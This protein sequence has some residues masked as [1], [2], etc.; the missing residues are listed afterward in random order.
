M[1]KLYFLEVSNNG[2]FD[3]KQKHLRTIGMAM[4]SVPYLGLKGVGTL[5]QR[6][7]EDTRY[8][9]RLNKAIVQ[10]SY[11]SAKDQQQQNLLLLCLILQSFLHQKVHY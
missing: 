7:A 8:M 2:D 9:A 6:G 5:K 10:L 11:R 3:L 4:R 1:S